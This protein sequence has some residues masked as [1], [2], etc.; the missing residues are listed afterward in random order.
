MRLTYLHLDSAVRAH[1]MA[2]DIDQAP[3]AYHERLRRKQHPQA[4]IQTLA[5]IW[6][7]RQ[8]LAD[9]DQTAL[10][11]TLI[12]NAH[13]RPCF[14]QGPVF[15]ISHTD[16]WAACA[17]LEAGDAASAIGLDVQQQRAMSISRMQRM[18]RS[19]DHAAI[20]RNPDLF[21]AYWCAR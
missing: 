21:F 2:Q 12:I 13:N 10:M 11:H 19:E 16:D 17:V 18:S 1:F 9:N 7:L 5:G 4:R 8:M 3:S 6:L 15:S 14:P 20:E